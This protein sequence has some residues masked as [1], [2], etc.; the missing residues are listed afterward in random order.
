MRRTVSSKGF[1]LAAAAAAAL[2]LA[3]AALAAA[4]TDTTRARDTRDGTVS[5]RIDESG[6]R[7]DTPIGR[8]RHIGEADHLRGERLDARGGRAP[9][10]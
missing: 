9:L 4:Q 8:S 7:I 10:P 5:I 1:A 2:I 3:F 6:I